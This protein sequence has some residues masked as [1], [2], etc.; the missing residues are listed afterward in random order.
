MLNKRLC[1]ERSNLCLNKKV[2]ICNTGCLR[3]R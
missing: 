2:D 3:H 1:E